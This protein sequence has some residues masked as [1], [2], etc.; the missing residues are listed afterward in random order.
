[1]SQEEKKRK[2]SLICKSCIVLAAV[3]GILLQCEIGTGNFSLSSFRMF[4]T[5]S[6]LAV[7]IFFITYIA[8]SVSKSAC[9]ELKERVLRYFKFLITMSIMLTGLV[10]HFILRK[11]FVNMEPMAKA[12]LTLLHYVV[13]IATFLDWIVFDEK[14]RTDKKM[15]FI[16]TLFPL[17]YVLISMIAAQF[18]TGDN[19]YPY[20]FLNVDMLG[21]GMV[22]LNI[23]LLAV[24][25]I[26]VGYLG[27]W[28]DHKLERG[29]KLMA[30]D[31]LAKKIK[32]SAVISLLLTLVLSVWY[33]C[34]SNKILLPFAI[35]F[36][37]IAYH[38]I[39]RLLVGL[40]FNLAMNNKTDYTRS[41]Y[42]VSYRE[43]LLYEK[44]KVKKWKGKMPTYET[45]LF[46]PKKHTWEEIIQAMCQAELVHET[47]AILS[48]LPI[49]AGI[50]FG[51]FPVFIIT[52]LLAVAV[53]MSFVIMQRYNRQRIMKMMNR[54]R[55]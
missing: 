34:T 51:D 12:G 14:G 40:I 44:L 2:I 54:R 24:A 6:N 17:I 1:M 38:L 20:P 46:D 7:A 10:A 23:V 43:K 9:S 50:W 36:G 37:T 5:L 19:K 21:V 30:G 49:L 41:W 22:V 11:M 39:M 4:T 27:V 8:V 26:A 48:F 32:G 13:P 29:C 45:S 53:D 3:V 28:V 52:S 33:N 31:R 47:I 25:F 15:P 35:T 55:K 42:Q 18:M 16:A